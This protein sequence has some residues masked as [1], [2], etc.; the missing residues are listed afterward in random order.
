MANIIIHR[1]DEVGKTRSEQERNL[2]KHWGMQT[3]SDEQLDKLKY[4][5]KKRKEQWGF[6]KQ[7]VGL[8]V[9]DNL[10]SKPETKE[11]IEERIERYKQMEKDTAKNK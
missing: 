11:Q 10:K 5:E 9:V 4:I 2:R 1:R 8:D 3:M 7:F 6:D